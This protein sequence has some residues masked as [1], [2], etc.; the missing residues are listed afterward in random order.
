MKM[1][2]RIIVLLLSM[3]PVFL[4]GASTKRVVPLPPVLFHGQPFF[5]LGCFD[6]WDP[7]R[8]NVEIDSGFL[9]AGGNFGVL[10]DITL[11]E[12]PQY[13]AWHQP[14]LYKRAELLKN[15]PQAQN[16]AFMAESYGLGVLFSG[17]FTSCVKFSKKIKKTLGLTKEE[18]V[19]T[20]V[21][22]H[23]AVKY[24]RTT[25]RNN[26]VVKFL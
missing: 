20:L 6:C 17:F 8:G 7:A 16:M 4:P 11:K 25:N 1:N 26:A 3:L 13:A 15:T 19:I 18:P 2:R 23:P 14:V 24:K 22:G 12:H 9:E 21:I 10:G 5:P